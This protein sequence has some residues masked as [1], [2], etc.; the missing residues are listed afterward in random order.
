[1][2]IWEVPNLLP[3]IP[4]EQANG[5]CLSSMGAAVRPLLEASRNPGL[6]P[7]PSTR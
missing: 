6:I 5:G 3:R 2:V 4:P 1:M 7:G